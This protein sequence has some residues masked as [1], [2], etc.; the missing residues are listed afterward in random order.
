MIYNNN[1]V[2]EIIVRPSFSLLHGNRLFPLTSRRDLGYWKD[3]GLI[4]TKHFYKPWKA[5][6][7]KMYAGD[8]WLYLMSK[9][10]P[11]VVYI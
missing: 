10:T 3:R 5:S 2:T 4:S 1:K 6:H 7:E 8:G 11:R 9:T